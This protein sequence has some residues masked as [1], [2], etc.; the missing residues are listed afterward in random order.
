[1]RIGIGRPERKEQVAAYVLHDFAKSDQQW[2]EPLVTSL[3]GST[4]KLLSSNYADVM[5]DAAMAVRSAMGE[6]D[7]AP[8]KDNKPGQPTDKQAAKAKAPEKP[9]KAE[10]TLA[11]K[12]RGWLDGN[13]D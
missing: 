3:A 12:L 11:D 13:K 6:E 2:L 5:N 7:K 9:D 4:D 8:A 1:M 10:G